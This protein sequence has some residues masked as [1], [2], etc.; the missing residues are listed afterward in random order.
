M[1]DTNTPDRNEHQYKCP[2]CSAVLTATAEEVG[3]TK[4]CPECGGELI[5]PRRKLSM[6]GDL[7]VAKPPETEPAPVEEPEVAAEPERPR[8]SLSG[9]KQRSGPRPGAGLGETPDPAPAPPAPAP[10]PAQASPRPGASRLVLPALLGL[11]VIGGIAAALLLTETP[12]PDPATAAET[13]P[14]SDAVFAMIDVALQNLQRAQN[15][16][17]IADND[18]LTLTLLRQTGDTGPSVDMLETAIAER[19]AEAQRDL[20]RA[21]ESIAQL[22]DARRSWET[23]VDELLADKTNTESQGGRMN[24]V[25]WLEA[26]TNTIRQV[27]EDEADV[28]QFLRNRI[29]TET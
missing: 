26:I 25:A 18:Q 15:A 5:V 4:D 29:N 16:R 12:E 17:E 7:P 1:S 13:R 21:I 11:L 2:H 10:A 3:E 19:E 28:I 20:T 8:L 23:Y 22:V 24:N 14:T 27:P 6:R 9:E